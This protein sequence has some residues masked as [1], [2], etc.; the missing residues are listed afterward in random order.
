MTKSKS[1]GRNIKSG[2]A[3]TSP[4]Q[5]V[6]PEPKQKIV[7]EIMKKYGVDTVYE[8]DK[9]EFFTVENYANLSVGNK[10]DALTVHK[11]K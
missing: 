7:R 4:D 9:G 11:R 2:E 5:P 6:Q 10:K 8:N 1:S 3:T